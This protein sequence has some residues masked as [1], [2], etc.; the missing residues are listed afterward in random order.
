MPSPWIRNPP[1][2]SALEPQLLDE[3]WSLVELP[4]TRDTVVGTY[5][6][7]LRLEWHHAPGSSWEHW[8]L[9]HLVPLHP[10]RGMK[11]RPRQWTPMVSIA[12]AADDQG[13]GGWAVD[14]FRLKVYTDGQGRPTP[15][16]VAALR[17]DIAL[18]EGWLHRVAYHLTMVAGLV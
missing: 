7:I 15:T 4:G 18:R 10:P 1:S 3:H 11:L 6:G 5:S 16:T 2:H 12:A 13:H 8:P 17:M 9:I 14:G